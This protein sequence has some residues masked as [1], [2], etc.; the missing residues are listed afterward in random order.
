MSKHRHR[1][2]IPHLVED[3]AREQMRH[4]G[5]YFRTSKRGV[6]HILIDIAGVLYSCCYFASTQTWKVFWPSMVFTESQ[7]KVNF[8]KQEDMVAWLECEKARREER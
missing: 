6:P 8:D 1:R 7:T 3:V 4:L 2:N 5:A